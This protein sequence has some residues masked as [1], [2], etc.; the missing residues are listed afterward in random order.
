[1]CELHMSSVSAH[2]HKAYYFFSV[3]LNG[4]LLKCTCIAVALQVLQ[5]FNAKTPRVYSESFIIPLHRKMDDMED[6]DLCVL[7]KD[8]VSFINSF[9]R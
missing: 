2:F 9:L 8:T 3:S 1:M 4:L 6:V 5:R 7:Q